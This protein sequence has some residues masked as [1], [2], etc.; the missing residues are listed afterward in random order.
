MVYFGKKFGY[1]LRCFENLYEVE[2]RD[3]RLIWLRI[4]LNYMEFMY[5]MVIVYGFYLGL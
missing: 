1:I 2:Y 3:R 4:F 5:I